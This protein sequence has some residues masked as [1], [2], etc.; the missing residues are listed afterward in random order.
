MLFII[1]PK[2][3]YSR[4]SVAQTLIARLPRLF[5]TRSLVPLK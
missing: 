2:T 1:I 3:V 5:R 4:P